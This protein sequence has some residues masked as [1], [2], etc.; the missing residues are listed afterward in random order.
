MLIHCVWDGVNTIR[1]VGSARVVEA[2][3]GVGVA[4][5]VKCVGAMGLAVDK[6]VIVS[7]SNTVRRSHNH[8]CTPSACRLFLKFD[9]G[10]YL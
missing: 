10:Y 9:L 2:M 1:V 5:V 7:S 6:L 4:K 8:H 3:N